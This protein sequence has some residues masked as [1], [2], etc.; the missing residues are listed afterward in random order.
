MEHAVVRIA[1]VRVIADVV[2]KNEKTT[3]VSYNPFNFSGTQI[4]KMYELGHTIEQY[5]KDL[6]ELGINRSGITKRHNVK[7][8]VVII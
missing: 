5:K 4:M 3:I 6:A 1:G 7:H 8:G 2:K